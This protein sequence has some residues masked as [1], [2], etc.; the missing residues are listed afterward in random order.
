MKSTEWSPLTA[1]QRDIWA[2][3]ALAPERPQFNLFMASR[4]E[5]PVDVERLTASVL[6]AARHHD[7]FAL[8]FTERDGVPLQRVVDGEPAV[9]V[10]DFSAE[11]D[12]RARCED[13]IAASQE[14][15]VALGD[16]PAYELALLRE[17]PAAV[18]VYV[19]VHHVLADAWGLNLFLERVRAGY[20][21]E[22]QPAAPSYL[23]A[24]A[25]EEAYRGSAQHAADREHFRAALAGAA[26]PLFARRAPSGA[27]NSARHSFELPARAVERI[28]A[29]G[30]SPFAFVAAAFAAYLSRV[31]LVDDVVLG[32][33]LFNRRGQAQRRTVGHF[34]NTLP[35]PV[36][37]GGELTYA[38]LV[39]AV[40]AG[41]RTLQRAERLP[42]GEV[43]ADLPAHAPRTLFDVTVSYVQAPR[44][45]PLP[46]LREE[47]TGG[48]RAHD[49][50]ALAVV[51][52]EPADGGGLLVSLDHALDVFDEDF[53]VAA[54]ARHVRNLVLNALDA[55]DVPLAQLAVLD[56][57][58]RADLLE[59]PNRTAADYPAD[60]TLHELFAEQ[61]AR[62]PGRVALLPD[63]DGAP[64][65]YA[66]L[67]ARANR[68]ARAL[69]ADGVGTGDR[70]AV[71]QQRGP[72]LLVAVLAVLKAGGAYVPVDP[73]YPAERIRFLLADSGA[74]VVLTGPGAPELPPGT[75][76]SVRR[77]DE[78]ADFPADP[79]PAA[80]GP[81]D[82]AYVLYT[83]GSTGRPKGVLVE[84][85]S[86]VNRLH[87]MQRRYPLGEGDVLLQKTP[88]SFDVSVWELFWWGLAGARLALPAP[89]AEKDPRAL[90][91]AVA[92]QRVSVLHFVPSMF[93]PFLELLEGKPE[94]REDAA[95]LRLVFC[96]GEALPPEQ[97]NRFN[98]LLGGPGGARLVNLYGPTEATVDVSFHDCPDDPERPVRRVPI[99][100]PIDNL[101][102][103]VL[104][105]HDQPQPVGAPGELCI[106]GVGVA[107]GYLGRPELTA[108]RFGTDPFAGGRFYRTGDL[109]R[110]LADGSLEYLGRIDGQVKVRGNRV[111]LGEVEH[112][113]SELPGVRG[114]VVLA[115]AGRDG[116]TRLVGCY[117]AEEELDPAL[118]RA[119]LAVELP[120]FMV[121][122]RFVRLAAI[123]LTPNGK[124]D[125]AAVLRALPQDGGRTGDGFREPRDATE[126]AL[127][128]VWQ[129]VLGTGPVGAHDHWF[130]LGGDS[131]LMLRVRAEAEKRGLAL[132][133]ADLAR[134]PVLADLAD[135]ART[136]SAAPAPDPAAA[137]AASPAPEP[138]ALV[139][140]VDRARLLGA[141]ALDAFPATRLQLGMLYHSSGEA[142]SAVYHDVFHYRLATG[143][144]ERAL[145][146]AHARLLER[147]PVLRSS[148]ALGG[149]AEPLQ[150]VH[151]AAEGTLSVAD[152]RGQDEERAQRAVLAHVAERRFHA[153]DPERPGLHHLRAHV[154]DG[155]LDLVLSF[156]H[157]V[158]D[159]WSV[160]T[161]VAELLQDYL[162][163]RGA[164]LPPVPDG[165]PPT[166]ALHV[167]GERALL[168]APEHRAY[169]R[170]LLEGAELVQL[171]SFAPYEP[172]G[173]GEGVVRHLELPA[174]LDEQLHAFAREHA[175]P[176]RLVLFTAHCLVLRLLARTGDV[177]TGLVTHGR[178]EVADADR[179]AGLFLNTMP[180]R[181]RTG[182]AS[183]LEEVRAV[184]A[185]ERD[186]HPHRAYPVSAV[187]DDRG[188]APLLDTAFTYV[189]LHTLE[190]L[191]RR[192]DLGLLDLTT[193]EETNF[194]LLLNAVTDPRDGRTRLRFNC[195]ARAFTAVQADLLAD[196]YLAVLRRIVEHPH[197]APDFDFLAPPA[198]LPANPAP[199]PLDVLARFAATVAR[200]P[201]AEAVVFGALR[202]SYRELDRAVEQVARRLRALG[203]PRGAGVGVALDRSPEMIA[204]VLG[205]LRCGA[206]VV[207]LD[208]SYPP[209]R[210][211]RMVERAEPF[212]VV[213]HAQ[214]A[215]LVPDPA[216]VLPIESVPL[217]EPLDGAADWPS[218]GL[219]DLCL[220]LFTSGSSGEPKGVELPHRLW[221][222]YTQW[223]LRAETA[224]PGARTLQF[225][226]LSFDVSFQ[227][228]FSTTA[229]GGTLH[230]VSDTDRRDPAV[231]L[232]L[233]DEQEVERW[234]MPFVALQGI[235]EA[236]E[237]LG[238]RP[239]AL[240][241]LISS[242]EQLR[243]TEELR[244]FCAARPG[245]LLENQYGPTETNIA[246]ARL[247]DGDPARWPA[248]PSIG[249]AIDGAE[250]HV[251]DERL[252]PVPTGV[253]GELYLG[254][255]C[256]ALG[257][258]GR[259]DLTEERFVPHPTRPGARL[260]RTGDV[261][262]VLPDGDTVWLGRADNQVKV[263]GFRVEPAEVEIAITATAEDFPGLRGAAVVARR[264][265]DGTDSA[266]VGFLV[267]TGRPE[268]LEEVRKRLR[269]V[270][271]E[272]MVPSQLSWLE[273]LPLTPS[274]KRDDA[275]LRRIEPERG[276][277]AAGTL[278]RDGYE[279][280]LA[281][282]FGELLDRPRFGVHDDFFEHGGTSLTAMRLV[283]GIEKRFGVHV[284]LTAFVA[285]P[286]VARLAERLRSTEAVAAFDPVVPVRS[287]GDRPP[288]FLVH[289]LGGNV[290]CYVRLARHLPA[291]QPLYA[292]QA[293]G[294]EPGTE[295]VQTMDA[296][297]ASYLEAVRRVQPEG[298]YHLGGWSFGGFVAFE[299]ARQLHREAPGQVAEVVLL[300]SIAPTPGDRP[301]V[302]EQAMMEWFFWELV[303]VDRGGSAPVER[304]PAELAD[305]EARLDFIAARAAE[306]G[307]V[308]AHSA[309]TTVRRMFEVY[310]ANWASLRDYQPPLDPVDVT[311]VKA[312]AP[313]PDVLRPM[314]G[315][316][317]T[318]HDA[319]ANG[320][321]TLTGGRIDVV[322]VA[323]DHLLL[324]D[325]PFVHDVGAIIADVMTGRRR[326][327]HDPEGTAQ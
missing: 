28:R 294:A 27:R 282:I 249:T 42:L 18:H 96:S 263:R 82:L 133:L 9:R 226:P 8:R 111:E 170:E 14:R 303:W 107:R 243:V 57:A 15:P 296:L 293:G 316:A 12:P 278:P 78:P 244:R 279:R 276:P 209:E 287:T 54:L 50:D 117:L 273:R 152:L 144:D 181:L 83:S 113:L 184:V 135:L 134:H 246:S 300:D 75:A 230:L 45:R 283:V 163:L 106:G 311:L 53:P 267:G 192:A 250:I 172:P 323:G 125:R 64:V 295:P 206:A 136:R 161:L 228:I 79:L 241:V 91:E 274:G 58:E 34:A 291:D 142:R 7:A 262:R 213:A 304:I 95:P 62:T 23:A 31:H 205:I 272:Y 63:G 102:L 51:I 5:G 318:L 289:P 193:Y 72:A 235:A 131:I 183:L 301:D 3:H 302:A 191:L 259:P 17:G 76:A 156:H 326:A 6:A 285:A 115:V 61:A 146:T 217:A 77:S 208:V 99:G 225:A 87:W 108:E 122:S 266:L 49:H 186:S 198:E 20:A 281:D 55:P 232:R 223:Q 234:F 252:R 224:A 240:R 148:F 319:P 312:T 43:L 118:I 109:A 74:K 140:G 229:A 242:G 147:H 36:R 103:Y 149:Y 70:V 116:A 264:R 218:P 2:A 253:Q 237:L 24:L 168:A 71:L 248:L 154:R 158:L 221:A 56:P 123:P 239:R 25:D 211:A 89:G 314:H 100:R 85:R 110:R 10:L 65:G 257:Y 126:R 215:H 41:S 4:L 309:R 238:V 59:G 299:M 162:A 258:R 119:Q 32:V 114:A 155:S 286:T 97:V 195:A 236:S 40:Q 101:R 98:R 310:K 11:A 321:A 227:E 174:A 306:V 13:W 313:L 167:Q 182:A 120:E 124:A 44:P 280:A 284:P 137:P 46:G 128:A 200:Q 21:G 277:A 320:W 112:R 121:P 130:A 288:L 153:Y 37:V 220:V 216:L 29:R 180:F 175:V 275:A 169:W 150:V 322:D 190:P 138:F 84:H 254:G 305:D 160:A 324:L 132:S 26:P 203:V 171:D 256:L 69:R 178:P 298:P 204:T 176:L 327:Q 151:P 129:Q 317:R 48:T 52:S 60:R 93:G 185:Q 47:V 188:G 177:T 165:A 219:D 270:L 245:T 33:P 269:A 141:G 233:M 231:L 16:G 189:R 173:D 196:S 255:A 104:D 90:L 202:W 19:K 179:T 297:A 222:N 210:I 207:P 201:D 30:E 290:L 81:D 260:Y 261:G 164:D 292:L 247:L 194:A 92:R 214:H 94:L 307:I 88:V 86:V 127:A 68:L 251:L 145:R 197:A 268:D 308:P 39:A 105:R 139:A 315:A 159:G 166:A 22:P 80:A 67:D 265:G 325:E 157:A 38:E 143:W 199:E 73:G 271:P 212:R 66:E 35:L 187:Q 1:C